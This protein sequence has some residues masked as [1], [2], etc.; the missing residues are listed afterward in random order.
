MSAISFGRGFGSPGPRSR[1]LVADGEGGEGGAA[2]AAMTGRFQPELAS[3]GADPTA[4]SST[5]TLVDERSP[6]VGDALGGRTASSDGPRWR[7]GSSV[8]VIALR[9]RSSARALS[10]RKA[11]ATSNRGGRENPP[12]QM[13]QKAAAPTPRIE[14]DRAAAGCHFCEPPSRCT[15]ALAGAF[16][17]SPAGVAQ[18]GRHRRCW[19]NRSRALHA[20]ARS[21]DH[22]DADPR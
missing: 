16:C 7:C 1:W 15:V 20:V 9:E 10:R 22:C 21:A 17:R 19:R 5:H 18:I 12:Q 13:R 14:H 4:R 6:A 11:G 8:T 3:R 2:A